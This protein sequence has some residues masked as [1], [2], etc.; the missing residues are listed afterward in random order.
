MNRRDALKFIG[1]GF[2]SSFAP[3]LK[4]LSGSETNETKLLPIFKYTDNSLDSNQLTIKAIELAGGMKRFI[5]KGDVVVIKPNIGWDRL[6]SQ[7]ANTDPGVVETLVKMTLECGAKKVNVF[8]NTCNDPR[9]C[10]KRSGIEDAVKKAGGN[11]EYIDPRKFKEMNINGV[12]LK[13]WEVYTP[14]LE[15]DKFINVPVLKHHSLAHLTAGMKN[16]MGIIGGSR[17]RWHQDFHQYLPDFTKFMKPTLTIVDAYRII[18]RNGP[19]GGSPDDV[20]MLNTIILSQDPVG[21]DAM[22]AKLMNISPPD[23]EY[24]K[25]AHS[26]GIGSMDLYQ[27]RIIDEKKTQDTPNKR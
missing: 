5:S 24:I 10:Y 3:P 26:L 13:K 2:I 23:I 20:K 7:A 11:I 1:I 17:S 25:N 27:S 16:F 12:S 8:D 15:C 21:T 22:A 6:P 19:T 9:R 18:I 14:A 4:F